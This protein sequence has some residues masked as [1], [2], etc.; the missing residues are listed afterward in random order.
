MTNNISI[1]IYNI[2]YAKYNNRVSIGK[3]FE[4]K[5]IISFTFDKTIHHPP[6]T[7]S[8]IERTNLFRIYLLILIK[9]KTNGN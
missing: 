5:I 4:Q 2:I 8:Q 3:H 7:K 6:L 9:K 1:H